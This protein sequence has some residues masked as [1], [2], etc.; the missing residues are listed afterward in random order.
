MH[1]RSNPQHRQLNWPG[2]AR[3]GVL[4][5]IVVLAIVALT[6]DATW[7]VFPLI[8]LGVGLVIAAPFFIFWLITSSAAE[9]GTRRALKAEKSP[10]LE[11]HRRA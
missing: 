5:G 10:D 7:A 8:L 3:L 4:L 2:I 1:Q 9:S 11:S 6:T